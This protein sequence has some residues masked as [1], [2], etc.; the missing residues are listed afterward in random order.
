MAPS[1]HVD[2]GTGRLLAGSSRGKILLTAFVLL[3]CLQG[4]LVKCTTMELTSI[5]SYERHFLLYSNCVSWAD[6][7]A[8]DKTA[9]I[10]MR[11]RKQKRL[12]LT[13]SRASFK[14]IP[15]YT[16]NH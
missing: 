10:K 15:K 16:H 7:T 14:Y 2:V 8:E 6:T 4:R 5:E 3:Y 9:H 13:C 12:Q 11:N 1:Q